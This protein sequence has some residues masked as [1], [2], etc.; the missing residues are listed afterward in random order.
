MPRFH[1]RGTWLILYSALGVGVLAIALF[2]LSAPAKSSAFGV[3]LMLASA[4]FSAF[5]L[6][7][8]LF[9][10]PRRA[11]D[12][13]TPSSRLTY[14]PNTNL[15]QVSDWL[16][17]LL[18]GAALTQL[19]HLFDWFGALFTRMG[20]ALGL[21]AGAA[22]AGGLT[23]YF[24]SAG[25]IGGWLATRMYLVRLMTEADDKML[26]LLA[27]A[28]AAEDAGKPDIAADIRAAILPSRGPRSQE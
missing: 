12:A 2:A 26:D 5:G 13:A 20:N 1:I 19:G 4:S 6:L 9:G 24:G 18:L 8:F 7:G 3:C 27:A 15:E 11:P 23:V 28:S 16:T 14:L 22:F 25:F 21:D 10:V 17:K